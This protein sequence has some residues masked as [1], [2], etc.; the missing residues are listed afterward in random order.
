MDDAVQ[1]QIF[2]S[3]HQ[4][5]LLFRAEEMMYHK[6]GKEPRF[7]STPSSLELN[8][9]IV[10]EIAKMRTELNNYK[11]TGLSPQQCRDLHKL[12]RLYD[13]LGITPKIMKWLLELYE[14][15]SENHVDQLMFLNYDKTVQG[16][17][18]IPKER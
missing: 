18:D 10:D 14:L 16:I 15:V 4:P 11:D 1:I 5:S 2:D 9:E 6:Y 13:E 17:F 8:K 3:N 12:C 7:T